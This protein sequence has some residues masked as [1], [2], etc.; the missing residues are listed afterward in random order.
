MPQSEQERQMVEDLLAGNPD[1]DAKVVREALAL[2][3][4]LREEGVPEPQYNI[5]SP[6]KSFPRR[7]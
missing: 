1:A 5:E 6:Y 3:E 4:E 2:V 7:S